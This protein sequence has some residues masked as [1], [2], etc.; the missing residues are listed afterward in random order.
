M[1]TPNSVDPIAPEIQNPVDATKDLPGAVDP[2]AT[3]TDEQKAIKKLQRSVG[4]ATAKRYEAQ[5]RAERAELELERL[6]QKQ[7]APADHAADAPD[8]PVDEDGEPLLTR[9]QAL[10]LARRES[11]E[12]TAHKEIDAKSNTMIAAGKKL[13]GFKE[14]CTAVADEIPFFDRKGAPTG[15]LKA[16]LEC[17]APEKVVHHLGKNPDELADLEGLTPSQLGRRLA[18]LEEKLQEDATVE[19]SDSPEPLTPVKPKAAASRALRD[20]S[21]DAFEKRRREQVAARGKW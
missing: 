17:E 19:K 11:L 21:G 7:S 10:D 20:L 9:K 12:L 16:I 18:K 13:D 4:R 1:P 6:R 2:E 3:D 15:F 5:G 8:G 14:A